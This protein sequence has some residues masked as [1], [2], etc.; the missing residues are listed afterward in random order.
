MYQEELEIK[1]KREK[2]DRIIN[3]TV[4]GEAYILSPA[5]EW[6]KVV[7]KSF[8]KIHDGEWTVMQLVDHLEEMGIRFGQAKSLIQYPIRECLRYIAKVSNKTLSNI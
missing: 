3:H 1:K 7:I 5:L 2:I 4:M 6:K 8:H